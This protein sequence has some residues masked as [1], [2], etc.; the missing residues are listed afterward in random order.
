[1]GWA[2][3][4]YAFWTFLHPCIYGDIGR[5]ENRPQNRAPPGCQ[6]TVEIAPERRGPEVVFLL[7]F[8]EFLAKTARFMAWRA[9]FWPEPSKPLIL[10][11]I[12]KKSAKNGDLAM[13]LGPERGVE[14]PEND[15]FLHHFQTL[16]GVY[17]T[18]FAT[19]A[20]L[21]W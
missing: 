18:L 15:V 14:M 3:I 7:D 8:H 1:M 17:G 20:N 11:K 6:K 4:P 2:K 10:V 5:T 21:A 12:A 13:S 16:L 9:A 19:K